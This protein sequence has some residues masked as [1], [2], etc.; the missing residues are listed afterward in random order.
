[1]NQR[2]PN[3]IVWY[4]LALALL[5]CTAFLVT[6][7]GT[8]FARYRTERS[9]KVTFEVREPEQICLGT[10]A[11][12]GTFRTSLPAWTTGDDVPTLT[13]AVANGT[14]ADECSQ[15]DQIFSLRLVG[16]LGMETAPMYLTLPG[17]ETQ[18]TATITPITEGTALYHTHGGGWIY[19]FLDEE[20]E[21][22]S[23]TLP[24]GELSHVSLTVTMNA[25]PE[26]LSLIQPMVTGKTIGG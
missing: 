25:P 1:M 11:L 13:L 6:S 16:T 5:L 22:L 19:T 2:K 20:G 24:G 26:T 14:S 10:L 4:S 7:T 18:I 21:E 17:E 9:A 3:R 8:A 12:D 15:R 23:W